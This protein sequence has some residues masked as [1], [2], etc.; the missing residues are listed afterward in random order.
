MTP[1]HGRLKRAARE[2]VQICGAKDGA[3][4]TV[5]KSPSLAG[6]WNNLSDPA[7][8][9]IGDALMLD[10]VAVAQHLRPPLL[11]ALAAELGHVAIRLPEPGAG[12]DALTASLIEASAEF[13][14]VAAELRDATR[15]GRVNGRERERIVVQVDE[16]IASLVRMRALAAGEGTVVRPVDMPSSAGRE[17]SVSLGSRA[18]TRDARS[19]LRP[20]SGPEGRA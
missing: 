16:A 5:G 6:S 13:G 8:P 9:T 17:T 11:F 2:A 3:A 10:E 4:A 15:D 14:D 1:S 18:A 20:A 12:D 19:G 7:L